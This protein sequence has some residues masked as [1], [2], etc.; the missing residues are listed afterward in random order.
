MAALDLHFP[1][2]PCHSRSRSTRATMLAKQ[3]ARVAVA[4]KGAR[5]ASVARGNVARVSSR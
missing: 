1:S 4:S 5:V 3:T 2:P